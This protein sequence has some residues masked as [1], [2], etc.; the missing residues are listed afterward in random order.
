MKKIVLKEIRSTFSRNNKS[1]YVVNPKLWKNY[2]EGIN[3]QIN[4]LGWRSV[5]ER[6]HT[7]RGILIKGLSPLLSRKNHMYVE[8][9]LSGKTKKGRV[10][11]MLT[12]GKKKID[13]VWELK[14][15]T[16][17]IT[18]DLEKDDKKIEASI[19]RH[20]LR[21]K[22][23][24][25]A[26]H[27]QT[28]SQLQNYGKILKERD[29]KIH[30]SF[31]VFFS[32]LVIVPINMNKSNL[33]RLLEVVRIINSEMECYFDGKK[34]HLNWY[35]INENLIS[36]DSY[37]E[38]DEDQTPFFTANHSGRKHIKLYL[39]ALITISKVQQKK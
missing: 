25:E 30:S 24:H 38:K 39:G 19:D 28:E 10:D 3:C 16:N 35:P 4:D 27:S 31:V 18:I 33:K 26:W 22:E 20:L 1:S 17:F 29:F 9:L 36:L 15:K 34:I 7:Q 12:S 2:V 37:T 21:L 11:L 32:R 6:E 8:Y 13:E 5:W 23:T 14:D